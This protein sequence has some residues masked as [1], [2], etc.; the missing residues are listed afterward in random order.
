MSV[1]N[2]NSFSWFCHKN[3]LYEL[4]HIFSSFYSY[5]TIIIISNFAW[6][7][8]GMMSFTKCHE[9]GNVPRVDGQLAMTRAFGDGKLKAHI[10]AKPD[11]VIKTI[12]KDVTFI[13]LASD[14]LWKVTLLSSNDH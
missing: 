7:S 4:L 10:T 5:F 9:T 11:V 12:R 14:G 3:E 6:L 1:G 2:A 13:I 8:L